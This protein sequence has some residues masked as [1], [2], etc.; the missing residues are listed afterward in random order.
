[1][2]RL[3]EYEFRQYEMAEV[4]LTILKNQHKEEL[5]DAYDGI[6]PTRTCFDYEQGS[7]Y[8]ESINP[9]EYAIYLVELQEEHE[10]IEKWWK[11]RVDA[12]KEA[13][14]QLDG[15]EQSLLNT[16]SYGQYKERQQALNKVREHLAAI[17]STKPELQRKAILLDQIESMEEADQRIENMSDE[18]LFEDYVDF[19]DEE[20]IKKQCIW[21]REI[22]DT[23]YSEI[24]RLLGIETARAKEYIMQH[25]QEVS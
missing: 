7:V 3:S 15:K 14:S 5:Q 19:S 17:I 1:M 4:R 13:F 20:Q 24:S 22:K 12:Y 16:R 11:L 6:H 21:L 9:A 23:P 25:Q 10:R 8:Q 2:Y 18:E